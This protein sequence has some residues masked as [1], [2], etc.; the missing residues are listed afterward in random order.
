M[1]Q[2]RFSEMMMTYAYEDDVAYVCVD[3]G[4]ILLNNDKERKI[5]ESALDALY[6]QT[7]GKKSGN[8]R[9]SANGA[10]YLLNFYTIPRLS[11]IHI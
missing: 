1:E 7:A 6:R 11:L 10:E 5:G 2:S 8:L 9:C 3:D 4:Q